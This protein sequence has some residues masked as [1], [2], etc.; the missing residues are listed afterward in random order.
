MV[1]I[2]PKNILV[3]FLRNRLTDPRA[4]A[5][6]TDTDTFSGTGASQILTLTPETN[7]KVACINSVVVGVVTKIKWTDYIIDLQNNTITG[8]FTA[9]TDNI[10]VT[11]KTGTDNWIFPGLA[12]SW[13]TSAKYPRISIRQIT[14]TGRQVGNYTAPV[15]SKIHFQID[16]WVKEDYTYNDGTVKWG[17]DALATYLGRKIVST[18]E[19]YNND[20]YPLFWDFEISSLRGAVWE[21]D[22]ETHHVIIDFYLNGIS[23]GSN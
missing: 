6:A 17:S 15:H 7:Y 12:K 13:L 2:S 8:T 20:L 16:I 22:K 10:V 18:F 9:G 1:F 23:V 11:Y 3:D 21:T 4:R 5:E 19:D 14:E